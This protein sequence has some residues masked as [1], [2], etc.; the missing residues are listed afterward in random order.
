MS[1]F[2]EKKSQNLIYWFTLNSL[3]YKPAFSYN[4]LPTLETP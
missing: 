1:D 3:M 2:K 4:K